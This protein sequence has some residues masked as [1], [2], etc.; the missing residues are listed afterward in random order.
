MNYSRNLL[1]LTNAAT[2]KTETYHHQ[3]VYRRQ[4][5]GLSMARVDP[6]AYEFLQELFNYRKSNLLVLK[7][8]REKF[9][10]Q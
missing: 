10:P 4:I 1:K 7:Y 8:I 3:N 9:R 6:D 5:R 2:G